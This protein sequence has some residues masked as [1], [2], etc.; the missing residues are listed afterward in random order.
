M[1]FDLHNDFPTVLSAERYCECLN[2]D[3]DEITS[4]IWTS[5]FGRDSASAH[6]DNI[7]AELVK[8]GMPIAIEDIGF[9]SDGGLYERLDFCRYFYCSL[10]WNYENAFAGGALDG[11]RLT[12][13]GKCAIKCMNGKCAVDL[14][15]LNRESF[16]DAIDEA[17]RPICS[18]TG[19]NGHPRSLDRNQILAL[20]ARRAPIGVSVVTKFT[21][22][23]SAAEFSR[24]IDGFVQ[25]YGIDCLCIGSDFYGTTDTP[26]DLTRYSDFDAV[27]DALGSMGYSEID[28]ENIFYGNARR[29]YEEIRNDKHL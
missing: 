28:I 11:G 27:R 15:H 10:T 9:A 25:N 29:F 22:A 26:R 16:Y 12:K 8:F 7:T 3:A 19:F 18:H 20:T 24:V 2:G 21:D 1:L 13:L 17:A 4:V 6:V 5:E 23:Y 14:A